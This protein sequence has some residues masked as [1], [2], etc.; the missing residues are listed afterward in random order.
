MSSPLFPGLLVEK[1][2]LEQIGLLD[3]KCLAYQELDTSISLSKHCEFVYIDKPLFIY[4]T[5]S[6]YIS[7][8]KI[9]SLIGKLYITE[10]FQDEIWKYFGKGHIVNRYMAFAKQFIDNNCYEIATRCYAL[11]QKINAI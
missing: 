5:V 1:T 10:K 2:H 11:A 4:D 7:K 9:R 8:N 6:S 3:E